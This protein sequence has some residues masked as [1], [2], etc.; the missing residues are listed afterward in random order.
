VIIRKLNDPGVTVEEVV[1]ACQDDVKEFIEI[2]QK[3]FLYR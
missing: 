1:K 2:R 3:Y